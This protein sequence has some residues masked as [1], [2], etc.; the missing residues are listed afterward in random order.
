MEV[1][2]F[3]F[4]KYK[5]NNLFNGILL[6][7]GTLWGL[8]KD[9]PSDYVLDGFRI[10]NLRQI[11]IIDTRLGSTRERVFTLKYNPILDKE[12]TDSINLDEDYNLFNYLFEKQH[13]IVI[14]TTSEE[15]HKICRIKRV[16]SD[17][18]LFDIYDEYMNLE[19]TRQLKFSTIRYIE[20]GNDYLKSLCL[21]EDYKL[22]NRKPN[23]FIPNKSLG[24]FVIGDDIKTYSDIRYAL[25]NY[26]SGIALYTLHD[27]DL[28][29]ITDYD[30]RIIAIKAEKD[31][32][33]DGNNIIGMPFEEFQKK[34]E[35]EPSTPEGDTD[36]DKINGSRVRK[37]TSYNLNN[38]AMHI[39]T[40]KRKII[41]VII[42]TNKKQEHQ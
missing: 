39:T 7:K 23:I 34:Y 10:A 4:K 1:T 29:A 9:N 6:K 40:H 42:S 22:K 3:N 17:S 8:F 26:N 35:I 31:C 18:A 15:Q 19:K 36:Y 2:Y 16:N 38:P 13:L 24:G 5:Q 30:G 33:W 14:A 32:Y 28:V 12:F 11:S 21:I 20:L 27:Y 37:L 25:D 41:S